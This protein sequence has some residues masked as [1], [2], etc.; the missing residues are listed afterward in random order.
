[1]AEQHTERMRILEL[2]A[3]GKLS[4][5]DAEQ[6]LRTLSGEVPAAGA[7]GPSDPVT[8]APATSGRRPRR[9]RVQVSE[10]GTNRTHVNLVLPIGLVKAGLRLGAVLKPWTWDTGEETAE[11][12]VGHRKSQEVMAQLGDNL[13]T[14]LALFDEA[15][16][17][18]LVDVYDKEDGERVLI[19]LE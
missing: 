15:E 18:P 12:E 3:Q 16:I 8:E 11:Q 6:L 17:G 7:A 13:D 2:V 5:D 4:V 19:A 9:L 14:L 1:M 10:A